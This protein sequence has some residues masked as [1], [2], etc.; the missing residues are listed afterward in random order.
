MID[1]LTKLFPMKQALSEFALIILGVIWVIFG[2]WI[3]AAGLFQTQPVVIQWSTET[4]FETAGFNIYRG[5]SPQGEFKQ[6]NVQ[7]IPAKADAASGAT[8]TWEDKTA[9]AGR[10]YYYKLEDVEYS[11]SRTLHEPFPHQSAEI[12]TLK[13][14]VALSALIFGVALVIYGKIELRRRRVAQS[15]KTI[16]T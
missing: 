13:L 4:E 9:A 16:A 5:E 3:L 8:Y 14:I 15:L 2:G 10:T 6:V 11:N 7:L 12:S 1:T